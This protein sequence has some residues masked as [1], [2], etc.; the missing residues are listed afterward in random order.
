[1]LSA[2][3][4][5]GEYYLDTRARG[6]GQ[7][8][9]RPKHDVAKGWGDQYYPND[10][11]RMAR[12]R[13]FSSSSLDINSWPMLRETLVPDDVE[14]NL[15]VEFYGLVR[16]R[17][18]DLHVAFLNVFHRTHNTVTFHLLYGRDGYHWDWVG[19]GEPVLNLG[20]EGEWDPYMV[21]VSDQPLFLDDEIRIYYGGA[22][23]HH[24]WWSMGE[25]EGLDVPEARAGW[26]GGETALGLAT[27]RP[28]GFV[29]I[30]S[31]VREGLMITRPFVSDG[32]RLVVNAVC[33]PKGYLDVEL[34]DANDDVVPGY[35]RSA[36]D[37]FRGDSARHTVSWG[38]NS[39]LP[40][41][42][43]AKGAKLRF[44]S[45]HCSLYSFKIA[46]DAEGR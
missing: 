20:P 37:T 32:E 36:C 26:N 40:A 4:V 18:G 28:E 43:L 7:V 46:G 13:V 8:S 23:L 21:E 5:S 41:E 10:P 35:E 44:Y 29:S 38:G 24:D 16:F 1:M 17:M 3:T 22:S 6:M 34:S 31:T 11:W 2:D 42:A 45:R 19:R 27:L 15:D 33:E 25:K 12:R 30:D 39:H 14:D 9:T